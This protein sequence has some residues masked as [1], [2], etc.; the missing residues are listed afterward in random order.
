M[1]P[2]NGYLQTIYKAKNLERMKKTCNKSPWKDIIRNTTFCLNAILVES[3][4][5]LNAEM[6]GII[7]K[8]I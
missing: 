2:S 8:L 5:N 1:E 6:Q 3:L 4:C 7:L